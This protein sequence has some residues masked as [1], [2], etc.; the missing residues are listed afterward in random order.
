M[1]K[2]VQSCETEEGGFGAHPGHDGHITTTLYVIQ[3][4]AIEDALSSID[5]EKVIKC[6]LSPL[7]E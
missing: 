6:I 7:M 4:L 5:H 2:Y 3:I 1:I